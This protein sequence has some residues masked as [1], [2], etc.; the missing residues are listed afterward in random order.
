MD[1]SWSPQ[2][3]ELAT[4]MCDL[5]AGVQTA[6]PDERLSLLAQEG[7]LGLPLASEHGGGGHPLT[8]TA[9]A[10]ESLGTTMDDGGVL[11]AAGAHLFGVALTIQRC[12]SEAQR[13]AWLPQL[14]SGA[15]IATVAATE[16]EAGSDVAQVAAVLHERAGGYA[17]SGHK[18]FVT[19]ADR[20]GLFLVVARVGDAR[21]L[22]VVLVSG[23]ADGIRVGD[24]WDTMGL[25]GARLA[26][27]HFDDC[28]VS[29]D[30]ALGK[31]GAGMAVFQIAMTYERAL[32]LAFRLGSMQRQLDEVVR[33]ARQRRVGGTPIV[34][35]Q[36]VAHRLARMKLRLESSRLAVYRAASLLDQ[37]KRASA[38]AALAKWQ[39]S[40]AAVDNTLDAFKTRGGRGFLSSERMDRELADT[41]GGTVHSGTADVLANVVAAWLG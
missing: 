2:E 36:A 4:R 7:V 8:T 6:E 19:Y 31:P 14:A 38:E 16:D 12:G 40:E 13:S 15:L 10:Y 41:L 18:H 3:R 22:T 11:L 34:E 35:H 28:A 33:F 21:G 25:A 9:L 20:A 37:G 32:V 39:L 23:A 30:A 17:L 27:V 26:P 1:F 24:R 5:G 29:H